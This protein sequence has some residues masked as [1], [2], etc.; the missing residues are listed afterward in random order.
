MVTAGCAGDD[1]PG[2]SSSVSP[3]EVGA[4]IDVA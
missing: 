3:V 1:V 2:C 4:N